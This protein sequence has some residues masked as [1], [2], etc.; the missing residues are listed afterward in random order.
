MASVS[1]TI[2]DSLVPRLRTAMRGT[3]P[4]HQEL[5]DVAAFK[6][7]TAAYWRKVLIEWE[8]RTAESQAWQAQRAA[9]AEVVDAATA[10]SIGI[11]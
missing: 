4:E 9:V 11:K 2:P 5:S 1:I 8:S 6:E 7:I 10:D 3:F